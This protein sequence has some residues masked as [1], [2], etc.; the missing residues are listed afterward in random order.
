MTP[1]QL[2][3]LDEL[4]T[5]VESLRSDAEGWRQVAEL[6]KIE[7]DRLRAKLALVYEPADV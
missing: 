4:E 2:K 3:W 7:L 1:Q 6:Q 5:E